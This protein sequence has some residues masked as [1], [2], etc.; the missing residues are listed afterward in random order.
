MRCRAHNPVAIVALATVAVSI[1]VAGCSA[2]RQDESI[3]R[4]CEVD[5]HRFGRSNLERC[6]DDHAMVL[7]SDDGAGGVG[8]VVAIADSAFVLT[9]SDQFVS[10]DGIY[11]VTVGDAGG[12]DPPSAIELPYAGSSARGFALWG[13]LPDDASVRPLDVLSPQVERG[14]DLLVVGGPD[15]AHLVDDDPSAEGPAFDP[16]NAA[17]WAPRM[18]GDATVEQ[19]TARRLDAGAVVLSRHTD[20]LSEPLVAYDR[21]LRLVGVVVGDR[22]IP[23]DT[24]DL[25][26]ARE[27]DDA[28]GRRP[29]PFTR[30]TGSTRGEFDLVAGERTLAL[31]PIPPRADPFALSISDVTCDGT[32]E[33]FVWADRGELPQIGPDMMTPTLPKVVGSRG[34]N[35]VLEAQRQELGDLGPLGDT[36]GFMGFDTDLR[37]MF[38][39]PN[40]GVAYFFELAESDVDGMIELEGDVPDGTIV[41][42]GSTGPCHG[43]WKTSDPVVV[44]GRSREIVELP[45][46]TNAPFVE[47]LTVGRL[48]ENDSTVEV[49]VRDVSSGVVDVPIVA[50]ESAPTR[51]ASGGLPGSVVSIGFTQTSDEVTLLWPGDLER[52]SDFDVDA[53]QSMEGFPEADSLTVDPSDG[54]W[55]SI[56]RDAFATLG[57]VDPC[58]P[59]PSDPN[60]G[61][62]VVTVEETD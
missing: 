32:A 47:C 18:A 13:P 51:G 25:H 61:R 62:L 42:I 17:S 12:E 41:M 21:A 20:V 39:L 26:D 37:S 7:A 58:S 22:I 46:G 56:D 49:T 33:A 6:L 8:V 27:H 57:D 34:L 14:N 19:S 55:V 31:S 44:R 36:S 16:A 59:L 50:R 4:R 15:D 52:L 24:D 10:V 1:V 53:Y 23:I 29:T 60:L 30:Q 28:A 38:G 11:G 2:E 35:D 48:S 45:V 40:D 3:G 43:T 54:K 9:G 5:E